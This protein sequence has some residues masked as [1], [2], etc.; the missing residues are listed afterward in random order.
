MSCALISRDQTAFRTNFATSSSGSSNALQTIVFM[1]SPFRRSLFG[2]PLRLSAS[3]LALS[4]RRRLA[5]GPRR[6]ET[7]DVR[8]QRLSRT[9]QRALK[10][11]DILLQRHTVRTLGVEFG[12]VT[13]VDILQS[14]RRTQNVGDQLTNARDLGL[15]AVEVQRQRQ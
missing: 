8:R 7:R 10:A 1:S 14:E 2:L 13:R 5:L 9:L 6:G 3:L 15:L 12:H 11:P 4:A